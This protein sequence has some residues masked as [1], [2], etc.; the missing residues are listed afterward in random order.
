MM[1]SISIKATLTCSVILCGLFLGGGR[2]E[3]VDGP[4]ARMVAD[5]IDDILRESLIS[6]VNAAED[7]SKL[8]ERGMPAD[9]ARS[10]LIDTGIEIDCA[11]RSRSR[12]SG[13]CSPRK[14]K[15]SMPIAWRPRLP[16]A[17]QGG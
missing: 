4:H 2:A 1:K 5:A 15:S 7:I 13:R 14:D 12:R 8:V 17:Y 9:M 6:A 10:A 3:G 16:S 11:V